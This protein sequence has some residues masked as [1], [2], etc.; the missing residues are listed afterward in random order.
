M[1]SLLGA[2]LIVFAVLSGC[3]T[4]QSEMVDLKSQSGDPVANALA[5]T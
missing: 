2:S 1:K 4:A 5:E 3:A